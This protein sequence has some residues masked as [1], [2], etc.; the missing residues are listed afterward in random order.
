MNTAEGQL[1]SMICIL[2]AGSVGAARTPVSGAGCVGCG[3]HAGGVGR[4]R[5]NV[6]DRLR[7]LGKGALLQGVLPGYNT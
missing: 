1:K 5:V 4:V 2:P 6:V 3:G 7:H